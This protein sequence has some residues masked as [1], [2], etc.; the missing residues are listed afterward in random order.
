MKWSSKK[1][2][3]VQ[4]WL[5]ESWPE[6][7]TPGPDSLPLSIDVHREILAYREKNPLL[8]RRT[9]DEA[10]NRHTNSFGYLYGMLKHKH[11]YNLIG[12][13]VQEVS[14]EHQEKA[15]ATLRRMQKEA[16]RNRKQKRLAMRS[17]NCGVQAVA[18]RGSL[19]DEQTR[20]ALVAGASR[21]SPLISYR[22][23]KRKLVRPV[24]ENRM[25]LAS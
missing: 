1:V 7:F 12:K 9:L 21:K 25:S 15:R 17:G 13:E 10:L 23:S 16:Q 8:S 22:R 3:A 4:Q 19:V 24:A 6:L 5:V 2:K 14:A 11:R 18:R 20:P